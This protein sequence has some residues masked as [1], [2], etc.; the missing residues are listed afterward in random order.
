MR[1]AFWNIRRLYRSGS[2][3][4]VARKLGRYRLHLV[5]VQ[6]VRWDKWGRVRSLRISEILS[7]YFI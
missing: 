1:L 2:F 6:D 5:Y 4:I 3:P 7:F